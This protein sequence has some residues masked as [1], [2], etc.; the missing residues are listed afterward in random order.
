MASFAGDI[1]LVKNTF[2]KRGVP[3][4]VR[5]WKESGE[6]RSGFNDLYL[7]A[8]RSKQAEF[9]AGRKEF[10]KSLKQEEIS[11]KEISAGLD[12]YRQF[13]GYLFWDLTILKRLLKEQEKTIADVFRLRAPPE[14]VRQMGKDEAVHSQS[15]L[16]LM[17]DVSD[18][19]RSFVAGTISGSLLRAQN[20]FRASAIPGAA[21]LWGEI[22]ELRQASAALSTA[23]AEGKRERTAAQKGRL[24]DLLANSKQSL[25]NLGKAIQLYEKLMGNAFVDMEKVKGILKEQHQIEIAIDQELMKR[26]G[27]MRLLQAGA[28]KM[29]ANERNAA[30][31]FIKLMKDIS[32]MARSLTMTVHGIESQALNIKQAAA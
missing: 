4:L 11:I 5:M 12:T 13:Y 27:D 17:Q 25:E 29:K 16:K 2:W 20:R 1:Q 6:L 21:R 9:L 18:M 7:A 14:S 28:A 8:K 24:M 22:H 32:D 15:F 31:K 3:R 26:N 23:R 10:M 30:Q 19:A